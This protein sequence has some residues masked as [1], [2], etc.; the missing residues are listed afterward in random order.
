MSATDASFFYAEGGYTPMHVGS[1][2]VFDGPALSYGDLVR[3]V[4][5]KLSRV[6]RYRQRVQTV[7]LNLGRPLWVDDE[8]FHI[9]FHIRHTAVP[10]PGGE[11]QL[12]NLAG[13]VLAQRMD[14]T[15]PLWETWLVEGLEGGRW[16]VISK[17]HHCMVD[18]VGGT[19]L[20]QMIFDP[21]PLA[22]CEEP[23]EWVP[24]SAPS[25]ISVLAGSLRDALVDP[26]RQLASLGKPG[27]A[28]RGLRTL[29]LRGAAVG[30]ALPTIARHATK[31]MARS[32]NGPIGPHRRWAWTETSR[33][34][35]KQ[36]RAA[37]GGTVN[38]IVLAAITRGFRDLL[39]ARGELTHRLVVRSMVPVSVRPIDEHES[40]ANQV[41]AVFVDLPVG[42]RDPL[43][44]LAALRDQLD[45]YKRAMSAMDGR[46]VM[47]MGDLVPAGLL[48][49]AIR[50]G[51]R[52][53]QPLCQAV[54]SNIP[55]P[56]VPLYVLGRRLTALYPYVPIGGGLRVSI[57][58]FSYQ[59]TM[60]FGINVD[61][62]AFPDLEVLVEGIHRGMDELLEL[63]GSPSVN[64]RRP[65]AATT[66]A[67][68]RETTRA[69]SGDTTRAAS[70]TTRAA[71]AKRAAPAKRR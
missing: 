65:P 24:E 43:R 48:A 15:R 17:V 47:A 23:V 50:T 45:T 34:D 6:P 67:A 9:L 36:V 41:S 61:F 51:V 27:P 49:L 20:M 18:G 7:P 63:A 3:L 25:A 46:T 8:H 71:T 28:Q 66:G 4:M 13:R 2:A 52:T 12:R 44:R 68:G 37:L 10:A 33:Q 11:E 56:P 5:S 55:G 39:I 70:A 1:V 21:D 30:A 60:T 53:G 40:L 16:A 58:I 38:D 19:D 35:V 59:Q 31:P 26:A 29:W 69:A 14:M 62:N 32:L 64:G 57:G 22:G 54:T 42:E